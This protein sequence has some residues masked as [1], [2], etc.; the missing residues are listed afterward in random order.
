M[1]HYQLK[2]GKEFQKVQSL[3]SRILTDNDMKKR[4]KKT[5]R[6]TTKNNIEN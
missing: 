4:R 2:S 6:P 5:K 3:I 1:E